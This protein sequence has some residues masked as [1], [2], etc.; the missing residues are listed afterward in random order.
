MTFYGWMGAFAPGLKPVR[1]WY[2]DRGLKAP[3]PSVMAALEMGGHKAGRSSFGNLS[4]R[5]VGDD[6]LYLVVELRSAL[7]ACSGC[8]ALLANKSELR[9]AVHRTY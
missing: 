7:L 8:I 1:R 5:E 2:L 4:G 9:S 3:S 6:T